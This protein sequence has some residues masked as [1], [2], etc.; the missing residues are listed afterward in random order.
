MHW[1]MTKLC[2]EMVGAPAYGS[3]VGVIL[4]SVPNASVPM[5]PVDVLGPKA[6]EYCTH[7]DNRE[8]GALG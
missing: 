8:G 1:N 4:L 6:I 2:R 5:M 3:V 7:A